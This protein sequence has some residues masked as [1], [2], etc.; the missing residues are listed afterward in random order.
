M[1]RA[2][3]TL[4]EQHLKMYEISTAMSADPEYAA[5]RATAAPQQMYADRMARCPVRKINDFYALQTRKDISYV[6]KHPA[7][8]QGSKYL[9]SDR[10][11]IPLGLDG[12]EH[13]RYRR[14]L[15]PVF[16]AKR[17][18]PLAPQVRALANEMI[19]EFIGDGEVDAYIDWCEPLPSSIS[20]RSWACRC[21]TS[22]DS[23]TSS[24]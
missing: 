10:P 17:V 11:A 24:V 23:S 7:V 15:D 14:L 5:A 18:A 6:N 3:L 16:T 8:E 21:R 1:T 9:G 22:R 12:P 2:R 20:C 13:R 19:D 4:D